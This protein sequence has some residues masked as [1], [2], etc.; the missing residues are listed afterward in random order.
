[1]VRGVV[2]DH[3]GRYKE[4][5]REGYMVVGVGVVKMSL[6]VYGRRLGD[7]KVEA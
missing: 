1:M 2:Q 7:R 5:G 4:K 3:Y 6:E